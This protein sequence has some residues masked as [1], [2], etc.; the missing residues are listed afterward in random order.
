VPKPYTLW[1]PAFVTCVAEKP[2]MLANGAS[3]TASPHESVE[4]IKRTWFEAA[5]PIPLICRRHGAV[6]V[7]CVAPVNGPEIWK[8]PTSNR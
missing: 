6:S 1:F 8:D 3:A 2:V 5:N 4:A 7:H